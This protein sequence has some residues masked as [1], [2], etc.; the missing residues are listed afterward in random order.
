VLD[1]DGDGLAVKGQGAV[2][3]GER[4]GADGGLFERGEVGAE[5]AAGVFEHHLFDAGEGADGAFVL[6]RDEGV[7]PFVGQQVVHG[8]EV[9]PQLDEDGAVALEGA[10][11]AFCAAEVACF[12]LLVVVGV[13]VAFERCAVA[14]QS[15]INIRLQARISCLTP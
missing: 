15:A 6:Q 11:R 8:A 12:E 10:E 5:W 4:R 2:D 3:L 9:L 1:F 13:G 14:G 7:A